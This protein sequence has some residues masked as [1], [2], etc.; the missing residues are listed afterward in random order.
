[1]FVLVCACV[2]MCVCV[3]A[4]AKPVEFSEIGQDGGGGVA[5]IGW[6]LFLYA[7]IVLYY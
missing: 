7:S 6:L 4:L 5:V 3:F 2:S 1:M